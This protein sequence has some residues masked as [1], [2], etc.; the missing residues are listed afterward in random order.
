MKMECSYR[1]TAVFDDELTGFIRSMAEL[2]W[3]LLILAMLYFIIPTRPISNPDA[4]IITMVCYAA[5]ILLFCYLNPGRSAIRWKLATDTWA[6]IALSQPP[7]GK[8][9][10]WKARY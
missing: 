3:L 10:W 6:M 8:P 2:Q 9:A 1:N 7:C 4:M 5:F